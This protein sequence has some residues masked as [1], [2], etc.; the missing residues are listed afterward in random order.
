MDPMDLGQLLP[1]LTS[2]AA[3]QKTWTPAAS[4]RPGVV[5]ADSEYH[6]HVVV[7][8]PEPL[9]GD[10]LDIPVRHLHGGHTIH[11]RRRPTTDVPVYRLCLETGQIN[12]LPA[13]PRVFI[14][15][16]PDV[17]DRVVLF[18][19]TVL[20]LGT[21]WIYTY[22]GADWYREGDAKSTGALRLSATSEHGLSLVGWY[23]YLPAAHQAHLLIDGTAYPARTA[24]QLA[25]GD[26][27]R[28]PG[29]CR[30]QV[31]EI[32]DPPD[33]RRIAFEV[34]DRTEH[35]SLS[36]T[37]GLACPGANLEAFDSGRTG[38]LYATEPR[39][40]DTLHADQVRPGDTV[41]TPDP[42]T[43]LTVEDARQHHTSTGALSIDVEGSAPD[44]R[45]VHLQTLPAAPYVLLH[46]PTAAAS[47][48]PALAGSA[49]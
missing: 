40:A 28:Q 38:A 20:T 48:Q 29:R 11:L 12:R 31:T 6:H 15:D 24:D 35:A 10:L 2:T 1:A 17:G 16:D 45:P 46:R 22:D 13:I 26:I 49:A 27:V 41:I 43:V 42:G 21:P 8:L 23:T 30:L 3:P 44:G 14:P 39:P 32:T 33:A 34:I 7:G 9:R 36:H 4:L 47:V 19:N 37:F 5:L 18:M 25:V